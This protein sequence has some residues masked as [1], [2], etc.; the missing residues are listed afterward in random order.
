MDRI[1]Q[2]RAVVQQVLQKYAQYKPSFGEIEV[3]LIFDTTRDHYLLVNEGWKWNPDR[4]VYG[5]VI[6][7]AIKNGKIWIQHDGTE[8]GV[9]ND[10]VE[11]GVPKED[12]ILAY[13][14]EYHRP[15]TGFGVK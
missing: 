12:I 2:Y 15:H 11:L 10:L 3:E 13:Y 5:N 1:A 4:R 14:P 8:S 9:A 6:H 7:I